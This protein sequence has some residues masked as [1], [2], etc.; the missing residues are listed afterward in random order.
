MKVI[1][2][3]SDL[4]KSLKIVARAVSNNPTLPI[5]ANIL[6]RAEGKKLYFSATNLD[7]SISTSCEADIKN[8]GSITIPSK[9]LTSYTSLLNHD[10]SVK[11]EITEG[12][13]LLVQNKNSKAKIKGISSE[14]YPDTPRVEAGTKLEIK[15]ENFLKVISNVAFA[16]QE[17]PS[18]AILGGVYFCAEGKILKMVATDSHR[19]SEDSLVLKKDVAKI[20]CVI[21]VKTLQEAGRIAADYEDVIIWISENQILIKAGGDELNSRLINGQFPD[22]KQIIPKEHKTRA[23]IK[24]SELALAVRRVSIFA[25]DNGQSIKLSISADNNLTIS[26]ETTQIGDD[27]ANLEI[28]VEGV[29]STVAIN[30]DYLL[31]VL[32]SI[33]DES[34]KMELNGVN[35]PIVIKKEKDENFVHLIMP[36]RV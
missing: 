24:K 3:Q 9:I 27:V 10:D 30:A 29:A 13:V 36:L 18:R 32:S 19:L 1:V 7:I 4:L 2:G 21:P 33:N 11:M 28:K 26:T 12:Q 35:S 34:I 22:Y 31:D 17:N 8:E 20:N 14:E 5:L 16:A 6:I 23:T 15:T 25:K